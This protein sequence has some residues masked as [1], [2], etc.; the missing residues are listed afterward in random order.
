LLTPQSREEN[1]DHLL[2]R[3]A[4]EDGGKEDDLVGR[5]WRQMADYP[6][7]VEE[8][9]YLVSVSTRVLCTIPLFLTRLE[10]NIT[11]YFPR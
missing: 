1:V 7:T 9:V 11:P 5:A 6:R 10:S 2:A 8:E 4:L 3:N